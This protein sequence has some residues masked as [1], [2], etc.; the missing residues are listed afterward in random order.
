MQARR[1]APWVAVCLTLA[2]LGFAVTLM[3]H[4]VCVASSFSEDA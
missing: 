3:E 2:G 1:I 4:P